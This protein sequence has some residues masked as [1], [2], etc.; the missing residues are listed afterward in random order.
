MIPRTVLV[1]ALGLTA[2]DP[3]TDDAYRGEPRAS[4]HGTIV[5]R[6]AFVPDDVGLYLV[7]P[8]GYGVPYTGDPLDTQ[9]EFPARF[10]LEVLD[11]P[12]AIRAAR[13]IHGL[14]DDAP[15]PVH[16]PLTSSAEIVAA[17]PGTDFSAYASLPQTRAI[18]G[19]VGRDP[20]HR[21]M[22]FDGDVTDDS[23]PSAQLGSTPS[24]GFH[25]VDRWCL[26]PETQARVDACIARFPE[27]DRSYLVL[28]DLLRTCGNGAPVTIAPDDLDTELHIELTDD[29]ASWPPDPTKCI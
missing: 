5:N 28:I 22:Y 16:G 21:V 1:A 9:L 4:L 19:V 26:T 12:E 2:C 6:R 17:R 18:R 13:A 20:W 14:F 23:I 29:V 24:R 10:E 3:R 15:D 25:V 27:A 7:W 8:G 11:V